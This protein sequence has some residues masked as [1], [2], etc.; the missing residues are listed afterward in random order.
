MNRQAT[1]ND[2]HPRSPGVTN[3]SKGNRIR[4]GTYKRRKDSSSASDLT[5]AFRT[6]LHGPEV[7]LALLEVATLIQL[8]ARFEDGQG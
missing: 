5:Q 7:G 3:H 8:D 1:S 4:G 2:R 6:C